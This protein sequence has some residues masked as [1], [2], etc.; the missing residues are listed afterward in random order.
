MSKKITRDFIPQRRLMFHDLPKRISH[1]LMTLALLAL[2]TLIQATDMR[3]IGP[4]DRTLTRPE[5]APATNY[6]V[7]NGG[8]EDG[9]D[10]R[11]NM[12]EFR[13]NGFKGMS[14]TECA[15]IPYFHAQHIVRLPNKDGRAYF[16]VSNSSADVPDNPLVR[17]EP[18]GRLSVYETDADALDPVTD[19]II[20]TPGADGQIVWE[21]TF[22]AGS[23]VNVGV[24]NHPAKMAVMGNVLLIAAQDWD[25][26]DFCRDGFGRG[27]QEAVLFYDVRDPA[28]P[29]YWGGL[30]KSEL[31]VGAISTVS[32]AK[33]GNEYILVVDGRWWRTSNISPDIS[34]WKF[35][36][37][38]NIGGNLQGDYF[39]SLENYN[40]PLVEPAGAIQPGRER[41]VFAKGA[42]DA[43]DNGGAVTG[44]EV[45]SFSQL[46]FASPGDPTATSF[47]AILGRSQA[48]HK[49]NVQFAGPNLWTVE[50]VGGGELSWHK[51]DYDSVGV[52]VL[53]GMP[54]FY[55]PL[56]YYR[57]E[58]GSDPSTDKIF[59]VHNPEN[60]LL[61]VPLATPMVTTA[62]DDVEGSLR[63]AMQYGGDIAFDPSLNG[64]TIRLNRE[65]GPLSIGYRDDVTIDAS[66][67]PN[68]IIISGDSNN[69]GFTN[70]Q[71][72]RVFQIEDG[73]DVTI[74]NV[75][76]ERGYAPQGGGLL[77]VGG[78][79]TLE[80]CVVRNN[81]TD[82]Y[83]LDGLEGDGGGILNGILRRDNVNRYGNDGQIYRPYPCQAGCEFAGTMTIRNCTIEN[84]LAT[85]NGG[86][87]ANIGGQLTVINTTIANNSAV[88]GGGIM[89]RGGL[90]QQVGGASKVA[91][92]GDVIFENS[93]IAENTGGIFIDNA[94]ELCSTLTG[95]G[96]FFCT[97][98]E[99][100]SMVLNHTTVASNVLDPVGLATTVGIINEPSVNAA[101]TAIPSDLLIENSIVAYHADEGVSANIRGT[102]T[103]GGRPVVP[104]WAIS[105]TNLGGQSP[106]NDDPLLA[107]LG[108]YGGPTKTMRPTSTSGAL[109]FANSSRTLFPE[110][111]PLTPLAL[112]QRGT[113]R[114]GVSQVEVGSV[115]YLEPF[116][117]LDI[118]FSYNIQTP[119]VAGASLASSWFGQDAEFCPAPQCAVDNNDAMQTGQLNPG[120]FG[121]SS[122]AAEFDGAGTFTF[123]LKTTGQFDDLLDFYLDG[124]QTESVFGSTGGW[125]RFYTTV[126]AG[127]HTVEWLSIPA[128]DGQAWVDE[129]KMI[130]LPANDDFANRIPIGEGQVQTT[131]LGATN[132]GESTDTG[133]APGQ[134]DIW[135]TFTAPATGT[136]QVNTCGTSSLS[137]LDSILSV[138]LDNGVVGTPANE[139][140]G[141][142]Q[143]PS[144][145]TGGTPC[146]IA[147]PDDA[148][149]AVPMS[150]GET[151][152][153]RLSPYPDFP[154]QTEIG[155]RSVL[156]N[157]AFESDAIDSDFD[158][159]TDD[160]D[161]CTLVA[162]PD[163][164]DTDGD[165]YGNL[166]D[167]DL[168]DDGSTNTL[169]L[170]LYKLAHRTRLGD[171]NYDVDADFNGDGVI[172]TLDLN[173]YKGLHRKP[174]GPSCCAP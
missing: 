77:N 161:N 151:V 106:Q 129:V 43:S 14:Y 131:L 25:G 51:K 169:D 124:V 71:D 170:N 21:H 6:G 134:P 112:D 126:S 138:H 8:A 107:P 133:G 50:Q 113:A 48:T 130:P 142:D 11:F 82:G 19:L 128:A 79:V 15:G 140:A 105:G 70:N 74:R 38:T 89:N 30:T 86:G 171:A 95:K 174:P 39:T 90:L 159:I 102:F 1:C 61:Q 101:G 96:D 156:L 98:V 34:S 99:P 94:Y 75:T 144:D 29:Q 158:G 132:D 65:D 127:L 167:G 162:N 41:T 104:D 66:N 26:S 3:Y 16:M 24:W 97:P 28:S 152:V 141:N 139:I 115:E 150:V 143:W 36:G 173:I 84:N 122:L 22:R 153:I 54:V 147:F 68:G 69:D 60:Q 23:N 73:K 53:R 40:P 100:N 172:N 47:T 116:H 145:G 80:D 123:W 49:N 44:D 13:L 63:Y 119:P 56:V 17:A 59:Q 149:V 93:T 85:A 164:L 7:W 92:H 45:L 109:L 135:F 78:N 88:L 87:V 9:G 35:G 4:W 52:A 163:Q 33:T 91:G 125:Q 83:L 67:L 10:V 62:T 32:L 58:I 18:A 120:E 160:S 103:T 110:T 76:I 136:M 12:L 108:D 118:D 42:E 155:T 20:N 5:S 148:T 166:C 46:N 111:D 114:G 64:A 137:G 37:T 157:V 55:S 165:G 57:D 168:N 154:P 2:P 72:T 121:W 117:A 146:D 31:G 27:S 81:R